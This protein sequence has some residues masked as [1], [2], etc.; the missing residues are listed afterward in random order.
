MTDKINKPTNQINEKHCTKN[1]DIHDTNKT[2]DIPSVE[3][4]SEQPLLDHGYFKTLACDC[5]S[6]CTCLGCQNKIETISSQ[7]SKINKITDD[8]NKLRSPFETLLTSDKKVNFY[9]FTL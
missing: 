3:K 2:L 1:I 5:I 6:G 4:E 8:L 9:R 7:T